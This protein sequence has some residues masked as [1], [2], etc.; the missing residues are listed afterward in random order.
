MAIKKLEDQR[1]RRIVMPGKSNYQEMWERLKPHIFYDDKGQSVLPSHYMDKVRERIDDLE[2]E[3]FN[4][5][6]KKTIG[7][8]LPVKGGLKGF[9][10]YIHGYK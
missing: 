3:Y 7:D 2:Q 9:A 10:N 6:K 1:N 4:P 5:E 8:G